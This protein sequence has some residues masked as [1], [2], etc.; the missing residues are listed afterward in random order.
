MINR[1]TLK[2]IIFF[3]VKYLRIYFPC[4]KEIG[5]L[6]GDALQELIVTTWPH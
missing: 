6:F 1:K 3:A 4:L 5:V 2:G